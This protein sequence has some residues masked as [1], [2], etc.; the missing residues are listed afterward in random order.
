MS[1]MRDFGALAAARLHSE[2][3]AR[4]RRKAG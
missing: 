1:C 2:G 4:S 3:C